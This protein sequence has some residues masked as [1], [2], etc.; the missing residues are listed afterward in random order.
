MIGGVEASTI[1]NCIAMFFHLN[2]Q[3]RQYTMTGTQSVTGDVVYAMLSLI[4]GTC[5]HASSDFFDTGC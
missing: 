2:F 1:M 5:P 3:G 4:R